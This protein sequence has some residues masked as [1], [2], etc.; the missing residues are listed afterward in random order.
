MTEE[1]KRKDLTFQVYK[2]RASEWRWRAR[3][4]NGNVIADSGEGYRDH[5]DAVNGIRLLAGD[6]A[7]ITV[8]LGEGQKEWPRKEP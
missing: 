5:K 6:D 4:P 2:D 1:A 8:L 7:R 3:T